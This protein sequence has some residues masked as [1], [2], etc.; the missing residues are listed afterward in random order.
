M[1]GGF[2]LY[3]IS[4]PSGSLQ[5][6]GRLLL[7]DHSRWADAAC[8]KDLGWAV[9]LLLKR[10][11]DFASL[12]AI[13]AKHR[14][15]PAGGRFVIKERRHSTRFN[16]QA[17][18][19]S[20]QLLTTYRKGWRV[21]AARRVSAVTSGTFPSLA[22]PSSS[23]SKGRGL[24]QPRQ[25]LPIRSA[26]RSR[27]ASGRGAVRREPV[28]MLG[29]RLASQACSSLK[30]HSASTCR[31]ARVRIRELGVLQ[32]GGA[33]PTRG[34]R[35]WFAGLWVALALSLSRPG[36]RCLLVIE[37]GGLVTHA[38]GTW[39]GRGRPASTSTTRMHGHRRGQTKAPASALPT[40]FKGTRAA[41]GSASGPPSCG[42]HST[43]V[44]T[45]TTTLAWK[46]GTSRA[47]PTWC[48]ARPPAAQDRVHVQSSPYRCATSATTG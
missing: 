33:I 24:G 17:A 30:T 29:A 25:T 8:W 47:A 10:A 26:A 39:L 13:V 16:S 2:G 18:V 4:G 12:A 34:S 23:C 21:G 6:R 38:F 40:K 36:P 44:D 42:A 7:S 45:P 5:L 20:P 35:W 48:K 32:R 41:L 14:T 43:T 27:A 22:A 3:P 46:G 11:P 28:V 9:S 1:E 37:H 15:I 31:R 19:A